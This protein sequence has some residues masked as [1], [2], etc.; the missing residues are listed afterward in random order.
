VDRPPHNGKCEIQPTKGEVATTKFRLSSYDWECDN[1]EKDLP[2]YHSFLWREGGDASPKLT[3]ITDFTNVSVF[4][5][6]VFGRA[7]IVTIIAQV[8]NVHGSTAN[9]TTEAT[10]EGRVSPPSTSQLR[11]LLAAAAARADDYAT[12]AA[13]NAVASASV[14]GELC[15]TLVEYL[16]NSSTLSEASAGGV[17]AMNSAVSNVLNS[18]RCS[19]IPT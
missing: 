13:V 17:E 19:H 18:T 15:E 14:G 8:V 12:L 2:L 7:E 6:M 10:I 4:E 9:A 3:R 16:S 5:N 11:E 1:K